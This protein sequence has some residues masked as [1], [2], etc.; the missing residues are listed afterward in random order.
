MRIPALLALCLI[1][2]SG[3][4]SMAAQKNG[5]EIGNASVPIEKILHG[6]PPKDGIP[7][8]DRPVFEPPDEA[9]LWRPNDLMLTFDSGAAFFAYPVGIL[10]WHEI[11]NHD[12]SDNPV[13]ITFC[14]LCGTG[15]AF[16]PVIEGQRLTF[17]VSGLLFNSD[18][19]MY[20]HQ[21]ESLWSQIEGRAISGPLVGMR[22]APVAIRHELWESWRERVGSEGRV[23][24]P[25][26][27]YHRNYRMSPYG[28]YDHTERL[29]FPVTHTSQKYH[30]KTWV[31]GW[32]HNG[33]SKAWPFPEL[34]KHGAVLE[35]QI[36][37]LDV[38]IHYEPEVPSAELRSRNGRLLPATRAFWFAWYTFHPETR[39]F[40][41]EEIE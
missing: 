6:G 12:L 2:L 17:G 36:G 41:A 24:S 5:F 33:E 8:I 23:L 20:D 18:L 16:D 14:P 4:S 21:T 37:G 26:T 7:F 22:L 11:V 35:D 19:L 29:F 40:V 13:V 15:I 38:F 28:D 27:G 10:N 1:I 9:S 32:T 30:P 3:Q 25:D 34:E 39:V 31:L